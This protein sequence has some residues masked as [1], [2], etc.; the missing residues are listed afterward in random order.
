VRKVLELRRAQELCSRVPILYSPLA[1]RSNRVP[2]GPHPQGS[3]R[4]LMVPALTVLALTV[5]GD[6]VRDL[7]VLARIPPDRRPWRAPDN[8]SAGVLGRLL[9][10][11]R[12]N[13]PAYLREIRGNDRVTPLLA[14]CDCS[15]GC[16]SGAGLGTDGCRPSVT[17][18]EAPDMNT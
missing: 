16:S 11:S 13:P 1:S 3:A 14:R 9:S 7:T 10:K 8:S 17:K 6:T 2:L 4:V 15:T 12:R 18:P 5:L